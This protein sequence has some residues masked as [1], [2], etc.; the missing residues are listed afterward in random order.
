AWRY[1]LA[2]GAAVSAA[3]LLLLASGNVAPVKGF[4]R[5]AT[6]ARSVLNDVRTLPEYP[7]SPFAIAPLPNH[8]GVAGFTAAYDIQGALLARYGVVEDAQ[9]T[10][11]DAQAEALVGKEAVYRYCPAARVLVPWRGRC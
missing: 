2:A 7:S 4:T 1:R 11:T 9:V 5:S 8:D 3:V 6:D 10:G